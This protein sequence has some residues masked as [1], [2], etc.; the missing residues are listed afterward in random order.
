M[1]LI[2]VPLILLSPSID[3]KNQVNWPFSENDSFSECI[4]Q[5]LKYLLIQISP[6]CVIV[7]SNF[8]SKHIIFPDKRISL[9]I[10]FN[11]SNVF[12]DKIEYTVIHRTVLLCLRFGFCHLKLYTKELSFSIFNFPKT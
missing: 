11:F 6:N 1:G 2:K 8:S 10:F 9:I 4:L 12:F 3:F 5:K 7:S